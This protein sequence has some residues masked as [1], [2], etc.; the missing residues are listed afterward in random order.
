MALLLSKL[1]LEQIQGYPHNIVTLSHWHSIC[2]FEKEIK[3][4]IKLGL[5]ARA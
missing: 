1:K 2:F 5:G 3:K 4:G